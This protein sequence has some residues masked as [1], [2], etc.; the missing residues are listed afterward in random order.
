MC[1]ESSA[2]GVLVV[3]DEALVRM[4]VAD[5]LSDEGYHVLEAHNADEALAILEAR[6]DLRLVLTDCDMPGRIDGLDLAHLV[7]DRWPE[8]RLVVT[9]GKIRPDLS[10]LPTQVCFLPKP[11]AFTAMLKIVANLLALDGSAPG[12][13]VLPVGI[14]AQHS[15]AMTGEIGAVASAI[16]EP[17]KS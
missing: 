16:P 15:A 11:Y 1:G 9:S 14:G 12:A 3:E 5:A 7:H 17:D 4:V 2:I 10:D 6:D 8:I 13:P